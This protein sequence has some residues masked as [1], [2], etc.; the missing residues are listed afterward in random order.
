MIVQPVSLATANTFVHVWH[1]HSRPVVGHRFS[2]GLFD[3]DLQLRGVA[4]VGRPVAR[5]ADDGATVEITRLATDG[6]RNA[7]SALY[8]AA[9]REA[10]SRGFRRV[11]TYTLASET[12][13]S[14]KAAGFTMTGRVRGKQWDTPRRPRKLRDT[15]DRNR[16]ER[17]A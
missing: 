14:L 9:C 5:G 11:I 17:A 1:R 2:L 6:T 13:A 15:P 10:R 12:G 7:C 3:A 8:G 16:W 4:I